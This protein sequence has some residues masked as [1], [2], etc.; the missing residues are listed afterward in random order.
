MAVVMFSGTRLLEVRRNTKRGT[1]VFSADLT[2]SVAKVM[3]WTELPDKCIGSKMAGAINAA[4]LIFAP[5]QKDLFGAGEFRAECQTLAHFQI[6]RLEIEQSRGKGFRHEIRFSGT[7]HAEGVAALAESWLI[8]VGE[9]QGQLRVTGI[10]AESA[11]PGG[12]DDDDDSEPPLT[13]DAKA[14]HAARASGKAK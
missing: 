8:S 11:E 5:K 7:F 14:E 10:I 3:G 2:P 1:L 4:S 9:G 13:G 12:E 6:V